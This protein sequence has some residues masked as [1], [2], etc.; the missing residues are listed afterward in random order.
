MKSLL[1]THI[2]LWSVLEPRRLFRRVAEALQ[3]SHNEL[4]VSPMSAWEILMLCRKN[5]LDLGGSRYVDFDSA[6]AGFFSRSSSHAQSCAGDGNH[7]D[8]APRSGPPIPRRDC[9]GYSC[10]RVVSS[11]L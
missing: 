9:K 4:W 3:D 2:W 6:Q 11:A 5:R 1:D 7:C 10:W 8:A